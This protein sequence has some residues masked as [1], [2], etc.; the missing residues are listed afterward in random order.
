MK[1]EGVVVFEKFVRTKSFDP[2]AEIL[3]YHFIK[4][5]GLHILFAH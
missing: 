4:I 1:L 5:H 2:L 3:R